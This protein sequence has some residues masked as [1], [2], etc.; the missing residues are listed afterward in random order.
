MIRSPWSWNANIIMPTF[1]SKVFK[2][3]LLYACSCFV[4][5]YVGVP[6]VYLSSIEVRGRHCISCIWGYTALWVS[7]CMAGS[8][9]ERSPRW[10]SPLNHRAFSLASCSVLGG[11][12]SQPGAVIEEVGWPVKPR[13]LSPLSS[14]SRMINT[15]TQFFATLCGLVL[16]IEVASPC[17]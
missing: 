12:L 9:S 11:R 3:D 16:W 2:K 14:L 13:D 6:H 15:H 8:K 7:M 17:L 4:Y 1:F 5:M 10:T